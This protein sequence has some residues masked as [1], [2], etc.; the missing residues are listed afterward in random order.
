[1]NANDIPVEIVKREEVPNYQDIV[2]TNQV[3]ALRVGDDV[4]TEGAAIVLHLM[5]KH[6][7]KHPEEISR[8]DFMQLLM[9]NYSTLHPAY[10][11]LFAVMGAEESPQKQ[12]I[13]QSLASNVSNL[14]SIVDQ[15]LAGNKFMAGSIPSILDYLIAI[16]A[17]WGNNFPQLNISLGENVRRVIATVNDLPEFKQAFEREGATFKM[18]S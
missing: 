3:P 18:P 15:R 4:L 14:W 13:M 9:F 8:A 17:N 10:G 6:E 11:K 1:M 2:A 16:Y 5:E 7:I 12:K